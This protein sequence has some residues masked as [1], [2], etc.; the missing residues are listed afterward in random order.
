MQGV[1]NPGYTDP[2]NSNNNKTFSIDG[3]GLGNIG[4]HFKTHFIST[5]R[6]PHIGV[7]VMASVYLPSVTPAQKWLGE[8]NVVPQAIGI[9]EKEFWSHGKMRFR[10]AVNAGFRFRSST[11]FT[12]S[13]NTDVAG[14]APTCGMG[15]MAATVPCPVPITHSSVTLASEIP[16]GIGASYAASPQKFDLV[17]VGFGTVPINGTNY[18]QLVSI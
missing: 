7:G 17:V 9:V 1:R 11:T 12:N 4:F 13:D 3:Q 2:A 8:K 14:T 10:I 5:S 6:P 15:T 16:Y 18:Y